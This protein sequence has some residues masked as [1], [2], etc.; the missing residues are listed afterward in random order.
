MTGQGTFR[1]PE[2]VFWTIPYQSNGL[3]RPTLI[4]LD[5]RSVGRVEPERA[6]RR[7]LTPG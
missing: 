1:R 2:Y 4:L 7:V 5:D 3:P 6:T